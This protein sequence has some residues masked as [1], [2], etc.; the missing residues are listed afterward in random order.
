MANAKNT[1]RII[2]GKWRGRKLRFPTVTGLRPSKDRSRETLF[3]WLQAE[4]PQAHCL[5]LFAGSGALGFE[6]ASRGATRVDMIDNNS[7][8]VRALE[9]AKAELEATEVRVSRS[10][11]LTFLAR[12][13]QRYQIVFI[14]PPFASDLARAALEQLHA[15]R[16]RLLAEAPIVYLEQARRDPDAWRAQDWTV[17]RDKPM[18]ERRCLLLV[19]TTLDGP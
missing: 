5:D 16:D 17:H 14:D 7:Q 10:D 3:N 4:L 15:G 6:A 12:S 13:T 11:A 18:G 8:V 2:G 19:P 9:T 1:V